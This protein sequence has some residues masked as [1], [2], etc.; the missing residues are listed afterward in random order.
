M[1]EIINL[2]NLDTF[3][4]LADALYGG[5]LAPAYDATATY[6]LDDICTYQGKLY[7]CT[8]AIA[9]AEAWTPAHWTATTIQE[10]AP[11]FDPSKIPA[12]TIADILGL[13]A[14]GDAV[15]GNLFGKYARVLTPPGSTTLTDD[16]IE[17]I[18]GG[19][20]MNGVFL[21]LTNSLY[22]PAIK[23]DEWGGYFGIVEGNA[24]GDLTMT[25]YKINTTTK[26]IS[27]NPSTLS[28]SLVKF[29]PYLG[30]ITLRH[31]IFTDL[32]SV[33]GKNVPAYPAN[34]DSKVFACVNGTLRWIENPL[35]SIAPEYDSAATYSVGALV[36]HNG[37]LYQC[38][39]AVTVA[40][41]WDA[42]KWTHVKVDGLLALKQNALPTPV[43]NSYL[44]ADANGII[45]WAA[46]PADTNTW[47]NVKVNGTEILGTGVSTGALDL[48][49][50]SNVTITESSGV[51][52]IA[53]TDTT[54]SAATT[55]DAGLM[56]KLASAAV[57]TQ[58]QSTKFLREDGTWQS[59]SY[60]VDTNTWREIDINGVLMYDT[61][62]GS[63]NRI[64][65]HDGS[66]IHV[67]N[68]PNS[69][70]INFDVKLKTSG[71]LAVDANGVYVDT[72]V[73]ATQADLQTGEVD[74]DF[75]SSASTGTTTP[76][77]NI[78]VKKANGSTKLTVVSSKLSGASG[79]T[80]LSL[81]ERN[82]I[83][84]WDNKQDNLSNVSSGTLTSVIGLD[85][86]NLVRKQSITIPQHTYVPTTSS[87]N[88][89]IE[90]IIKNGVVIE[91]WRILSIYAYTEPST[92]TGVYELL[93]MKVSVDSTDPL[94]ASITSIVLYKSDGTVLSS[95][96]D[97]AFDIV[98]I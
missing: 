91:P 4:Q 98:H 78:V 66:G 59:P 74:L 52:T 84:K 32:I 73:I 96:T 69:G 6:E 37:L 65:F 55:S 39:T 57:S 44:H 41:E 13:D 51:V 40:E 14:D 49:Q 58:T 97:Y 34:T 85:S 62:I 7:K 5:N 25:T 31:A 89:A 53:A 30:R 12:G 60:T 48:Q 87:I 77:T 16:Y 71:G 18:T 10:Y 68:T 75:N 56:P 70:D 61:T 47:R 17:A 20:F 54:Y 22:Y 93:S 82:D 1:N 26:V 36:I 23:I 29:D 9:V 90:N 24:G 21:S 2:D 15:K 11:G 92:T 81:V 27:L 35:A 95:Y 76:L 79:N 28:S 64:N 45:E 63:Q 83:Y 80:E 50:G 8:T 33:N 72:S 46:V 43:V 67:Y 19:A 3:K 94:A 42:A 86:S 88:T 38:S